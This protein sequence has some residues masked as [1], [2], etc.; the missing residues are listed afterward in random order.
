MS[1]H[2]DK[3]Y[4]AVADTFDGDCTFLDVVALITESMR[5][6]GR[7]KRVGAEERRQTVLV[8]VK[9]II[10]DKFTGDDKDKALDIVDSI[11]LEVIEGLYWAGKQS[12]RVFRNAKS[13]CC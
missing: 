10:N 5:E 3:V 11:G 8:V 12:K 2:V 13:L 4:D 6:V 9:R 1:S 7:L